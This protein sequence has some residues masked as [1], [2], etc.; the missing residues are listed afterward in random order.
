MGCYRHKNWQRDGAVRQDEIGGAGFGGLEKKIL[1]SVLYLNEVSMMVEKVI[2]RLDEIK[3]GLTE[4]RAIISNERAGDSVEIDMV[5]QKE[6]VLRTACF[7]VRLLIRSIR[8]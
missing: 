3:D 5:L 1:L 4:Q 8:V 2:S 7:G 6:K